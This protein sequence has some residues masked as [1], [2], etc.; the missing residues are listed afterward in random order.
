MEKLFGCTLQQ[1]EKS[2]KASEASRAKLDQRLVQLPGFVA[3]GISPE[4]IAFQI[5][6]NLH[7]A[8]VASTIPETAGALKET[9]KQVKN[10]SEEFSAAAKEI[11]KS[12]GGAA[13]KAREAISNID[14]AITS[15]STTA[16]R[17]V[18]D[19]STGFHH[20]YWWS[21]FVFIIIALLLGFWAGILFARQLELPVQNSEHISIPAVQEPLPVKA[22]TK[23]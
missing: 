23:Q 19:L 13:E 18:K 11:A 5:N 2:F 4:N 17:A 3:A 15:A 16:R 20:Q 10:A 1:F 6:K 14:E 12:Y 22:K 8:F 9:A 7:Q 21:V